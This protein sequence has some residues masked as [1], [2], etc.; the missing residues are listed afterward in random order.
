MMGRPLQQG[1]GN[2]KALPLT[3]EQAYEQQQ[4][5]Q[6]QPEQ[7]VPASSWPRTWQDAASWQAR[8]PMVAGSLSGERGVVCV[9]V[10][11]T[12]WLL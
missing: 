7:E 2:D 12:V 8:D 4:Q 10:C 6:Q 1:G 11:A 5:Q 3:I 9:C